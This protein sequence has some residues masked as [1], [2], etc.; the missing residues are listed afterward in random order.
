MTRPADR[1][2]MYLRYDTTISR[3][4]FRTLD[5][6]TRLQNARR[7]AKP[8]QKPIIAVAAGRQL[9]DYGIRSVSQNS[10]KLSNIDEQAQQDS[11]QAAVSEVCSHRGVIEGSACSF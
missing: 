9:S 7:L 5:A 11:P 1:W 4:F 8:P 6:L 10:A 3:E 2:Q